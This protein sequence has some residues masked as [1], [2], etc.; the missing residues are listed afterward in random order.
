MAEP[1][2]GP[3]PKEALEY[4]QRKGLRVGFDYRDVWRDE[5]AQHFTVAKVTHAEVLAS[6]KTSLEQAIERGESFQAWSRNIQPELAKAGWWGEREVVD[7]E[8]GEIAVTDLSNPRRLQTIFETNMRSARAA[9][10][11]QRIQRTKRALPFLL[12]QVGPSVHHREDHLAWH[13]TLLPADDPWWNSHMPQNGWGCKCHVRQVGR[14]EFERLQGEGLSSPAIRESP[15]NGKPQSVQEMR[16][17][18]PTGRLVMERRPVQTVAP[19]IRTRQ[20][21][22]KR[23][24]QTERVPVGIDP[25][26][27]TN[28][29]KVFRVDQAA[30]Q[31]T[32]KLVQ[33]P[34]DI[35]AESFDS[36]R[37]RV[38]PV[39]QRQYQDFATPVLDW[40]DRN[41]GVDKPARDKGGAPEKRL[42]VV[43]SL[44]PGTIKSL[45]ARGQEPLSAAVT[46]LDEDVAHL[47]R[48]VK[49]SREG[50]LERDEILNLP[51][52]I[53]SPEAVLWD[54][55][56]PGLLYVFSVGA[57]KAK[58][59][60]RINYRTKGRNL[61]GD[62]V[63]LTTNA[64]TTGGRVEEFNLREARYEVI[65]GKL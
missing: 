56:D 57:D 46:L 3:V 33:L 23:T 44:R 42:M 13:G 51:S 18:V 36:V 31:Y 37:D 5:H 39:V 41:A 60:V 1:Q 62:K 34:A 55:Q 48:E 25:G 26:F 16:D 59:V 24:G 43:G 65:E 21:L 2:A 63:K 11:W 27:D 29:G 7:D 12:Y 49:R 61:A 53:D 17:G 20:W 6:V 50:R 32:Q 47:Y 19:P 14:A 64:V 10:Q 54:Q 58:M 40:V 52:L 28:P 45:V 15:D 35:G 9:G 4:F 30:R 22:N 38:L 8:T